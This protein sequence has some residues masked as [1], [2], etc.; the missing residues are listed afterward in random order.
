MKNDSIVWVKNLSKGFFGRTVLEDI[1][2][3]VGKGCFCALLGENGAGKSTLLNILM[4]HEVP[5]KGTG[6]ILGQDIYSDLAAQKNRIGLVTEKLSYDLPVSIG[7]FMESYGK[8][9][10][11]WNHDLFIELMEKRNLDL[12]THFSEFSRGQKM[13]TALIAAL[14]VTPELLLI[15]EVTSV[16][17]IY[18]RKFFME[19]LKDFTR[20]GGTVIVTTNI[21]SEIQ[22]FID[23]VILLNRGKIFINEYLKDIPAK[24]IKIRCKLGT[25]QSRHPLFNHA[26]CFWSG[27]NSDG[28]SSFIVPVQ[29][30]SA[31]QVGPEILDKRAATLDEIFIYY[32]KMREI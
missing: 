20:G 26:Q 12:K 6:E 28:S 11:R 15:D 14:C 21:I 31:F 25:P 23:K 18:S 2:F 3:E 1:T 24:F 13:Q 8:F 22:Y 30:A 19:I 10:E 16:L 32:V 29:T 17:D 5:E 9:F 4:G 27:T 7:A